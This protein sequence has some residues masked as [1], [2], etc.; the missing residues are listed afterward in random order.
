MVK[1]KFSKIFRCS[2]PF[3]K[4]Q[5]SPGHSGRNICRDNLDKHHFYYLVPAGIFSFDGSEGSLL[6]KNAIKSA[7]KFNVVAS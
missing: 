3:A 7:G 1:S 5:C 6:L 2:A 4:I